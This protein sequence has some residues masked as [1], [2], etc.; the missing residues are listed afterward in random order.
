MKPPSLPA[1]LFAALAFAAGFAAAR[2]PLTAQAQAP[3]PL[4][5]VQATYIPNI[6]LYTPPTTS[7]HGP[8]R[9]AFFAKTAGATVLYLVGTLPAHTHAQSNEIQYVISGKGTE[10]FGKCPV[11]I[12]PGTL[13]VIPHGTIHSGM[14][15]TQGPLKLM[16]ILTP[17]GTDHIP[18]SPLPCKY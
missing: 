6:T 3:S 1:A 15:V 18:A 12:G 13:L 8:N 10:Y 5:A 11:P 9:E 16:A 7:P 4:P 2:T 14:N 17:P